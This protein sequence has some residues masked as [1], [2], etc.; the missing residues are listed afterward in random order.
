MC[1]KPSEAIALIRTF[2]SKTK[3]E[4][5]EYEITDRTET[6]LEVRRFV[7]KRN[8]ILA[9]ENKCQNLDSSIQKFDKKSNILHQK[10]LICLKGI[11]D[12]LVQLDD[13]QQKIYS[14]A[15]DKSKILNIMGTITGKA[16]MQGLKF[17]LLIKQ[18]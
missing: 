14:I 16:F 7:T 9:L 1:W 3:E 2:N 10:G 17:D 13:Y 5:E 15:R 4:H 11:G 12:K 6:I 18:K 8:V